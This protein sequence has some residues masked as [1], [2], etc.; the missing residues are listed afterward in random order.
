M[1]KKYHCGHRKGE[2]ASNCRRHD[3][4][5]QCE[6][7]RRAS[8]WC[9]SFKWN[10]R[11]YLC[12]LRSAP[13]P[14]CKY[15]P[16]RRTV[17]VF[18]N[19]KPVKKWGIGPEGRSRAT[20]NCNH[21]YRRLRRGGPKFC[22]GKG[23]EVEADIEAEADAQE[24]VEAGRT[25]TI[26][27][28]KYHCGHRKGEKAGNCRRHDCRWQCERGRRASAWCGSFKW[29]QRRYLCSLRSAPVPTCK[30]YPRRR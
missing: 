5:W 12:S 9:G 10:Q 13:V 15:Y 26:N 24:D 2:K 18:C 23:N 19:G 8:A 25:L 17:M 16:R 4:R 21:A 29:N 1:G 3:C 14:T 20:G 11:R 30:Y 28:K 22:Q 27:M 7:G 6:R